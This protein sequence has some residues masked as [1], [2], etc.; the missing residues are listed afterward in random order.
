[1]G[2]VGGEATVS[3]KEFVHV[4]GIFGKL[5]AILLMHLTIMW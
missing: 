4:P 1:M 5:M 3:S 2:R